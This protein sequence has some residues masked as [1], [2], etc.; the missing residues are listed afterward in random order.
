MS[1]QIRELGFKISTHTTGLDPN[2]RNIDT[3]CK[4]R[5]DFDLV[6][7]NR[8]EDAIKVFCDGNVMSKGTTNTTGLVHTYFANVFGPAQYKE[9]HESVAKKYFEAFFK[10]HIYVG[11]MRTRLGISGWERKGPEE[12]AR[13]LLKII[14]TQK[15]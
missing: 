10:N 13:E 2:W 12:T 6:F 9:L 5:S 3:L 8:P 11:Q 7:L 15:S 1:R 14:S 4:L